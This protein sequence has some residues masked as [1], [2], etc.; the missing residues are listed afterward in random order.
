[1]DT[2]AL[3]HESWLL[4]TEHQDQDHGAERVALAL[5]ARTGGPLSVVM[6]LL[7]NAEYE[8]EAPRQAA[9]AEADL[10]TRRA[11]LE[12][13][14]DAAGVRIALTVRRG[15]DAAVEILHEARERGA[16]LLIIRRRGRQGLMAQLLVGEMVMRVLARSPCSVL[17]VPRD[18]HAPAQAVLAA[19]TVPFAASDAQSLVAEAASHAARLQLPLHLLGVASK[20]SQRGAAQALLDHAAQALASPPASMQLQIGAPVATIGAAAATCGADLIVVPRARASRW[21]QLR[22]P[23]VALQVVGHATS[24]VLVHVSPNRPSG[25][26]ER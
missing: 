16:R 26:V 15:A 8:A 4:A 7:S 18:T 6:P 21:A 24:A 9:Q 25:P 19:L 10:A 14:A 5:A 11:A 20:E 2:D 1:M 12:S 22:S 17:V 23:D 3:P 13:L